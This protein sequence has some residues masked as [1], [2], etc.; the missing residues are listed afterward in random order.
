MQDMAQFMY[1]NIIDCVL[2]RH[3]QPPA[4]IQAVLSGA[5]TP[6]SLC[7]IDSNLLLGILPFSVHKSYPA[8]KL[9]PCN[10]SGKAAVPVRKSSSSLPLQKK[11]SPH[12]KM[13][14]PHPDIPP[15]T[16]PPTEEIF[17]LKGKG[18]QP[19]SFSFDLILMKRNP[20]RFC[21]TNRSISFCKALRCPDDNASILLN[22]YHRCFSLAADQ[23]IFHHLSPFLSVKSSSFW[24]YNKLYLPIFQNLKNPD[25]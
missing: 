1:H 11:M 6:S 10:L 3:H 4:E 13:A 5:G 2:R 16:S 25:C 12:N 20:I 8:T 24:A 18:T 9:F 21:C 19:L 23:R 15:E 7:S 22:L 14:F 17:H